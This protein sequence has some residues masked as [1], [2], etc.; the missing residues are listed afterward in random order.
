M[1]DRLHDLPSSFCRAPRSP[2]WPLGLG[3][4]SWAA[5]SADAAPLTIASAT[6]GGLSSLSVRS[7]LTVE[8]RSK[9]QSGQGCVGWSQAAFESVCILQRYA[10]VA[11]LPGPAHH[12]KAPL[13]EY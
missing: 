10:R 4:H 13:K 7:S 1:A 8:Y 5:H 9:S 6:A 11:P 2:S 12:L 3:S